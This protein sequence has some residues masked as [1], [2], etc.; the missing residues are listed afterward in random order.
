MLLIN[1]IRISLTLR[2]A[3]HGHRVALALPVARHLAAAFVVLHLLDPP[4]LLE[5]LDKVAND[6]A[7]R[8]GEVLGA[9]ATALAIAE[10]LAEP[11]NASALADVD[12]PHDGGGADVHPVPIQRAK[13]LHV[14]GLHVLGPL[15]NVDLVLVLHVLREGLDEL[16]RVHVLERGNVA[17]SQDRLHAATSRSAGKWKTRALE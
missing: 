7:T 9:G 15:R 13:L 14:P 10:G 2:S 1:P 11:A 5:L 17:R 8:L 16:L 12:L 4:E 3:L 6:L